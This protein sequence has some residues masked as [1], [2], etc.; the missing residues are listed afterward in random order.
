[1]TQGQINVTNQRQRKLYTKINLLNYKFQTVDEIS[2]VVLES[3]NFTTSASSD[4]RRTCSLSLT[5]NKSS[6]MIKSGS[7]IWLDKYVKIYIGIEN[8]ALSKIEWTNMGIYMINNPSQTYDATN[9]IINIQGIDL[10]GKMTGLRNGSLGGVDYII[11]IGTN[12]RSSIISILKECGFNRYSVSECSIKTTPYEIRI[13]SG[14]TY[15]Q[16]LEELKNIM[17]QYQMYFDVGGVFHYDLISSG[18]NEQIKIDDNIWKNVLLNYSVDTNFEDI[19]N[20]IEVYGKTFD[21]NNYG[22]KSTTTTK[23]VYKI[24]V[25][26]ITTNTISNNT[27]IGFTTNTN[28][29]SGKIYLKVNSI[30]Q[31]EIKDELGNTPTLKA[32]TYYVVIY[33]SS[34]DYFEFRGKLQPYAFAYDSNF[35]SPFYINGSVGKIRIVL[36]GGEYDNITSD[37]LAKERAN[38]ELYNRCKLKDNITL[39]CI[40]IYW[41]DVN[42]L[43]EITLP[44]KQGIEETNK[45]ITKEI[46]T[47]L[48][49]DGTQ[50][51][52]CMRYYPYYE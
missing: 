6:F 48:G 50:T 2:G 12:I 34:G 32:N 43:I 41:A 10:M 17:P 40:P 13:S 15:Y 16:I 27:L 9:N 35:K 7:Q 52:N 33:K 20:Y 23:N 14:G 36:Q 30:A 37:I 1:M 42:E 19:K 26:T 38:W 11:P 24:T 3:P 28:S 22:G 39:N 49:V 18:D 5:P 44:N 46:N 47:T 51:I 4:I 25:A 45:Y 31:K 8:I 21:I 29:V